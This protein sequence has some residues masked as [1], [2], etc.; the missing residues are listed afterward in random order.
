[1]QVKITEL[2]FL[3][4]QIG[5][6]PSVRAYSAGKPGRNRNSRTL[7]ADGGA[8]QY[9]ARGGDLAIAGKIVCAFTL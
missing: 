3:T 6:N 5:K 7:L 8:K 1:M 4:S 9:R 2:P